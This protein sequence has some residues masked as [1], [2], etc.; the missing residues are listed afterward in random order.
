MIIHENPL[1]DMLTLAHKR[2]KEWQWFKANKKPNISGMRIMVWFE[3][4]TQKII[5]TGVALEDKK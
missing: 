5:E 3:D 4:G 1:E 2:Y